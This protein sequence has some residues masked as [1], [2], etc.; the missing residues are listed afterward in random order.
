MSAIKQILNGRNSGFREVSRPLTQWQEER[1]LLGETYTS[2]VEVK[3]P[4][5]FYIR[6]MRFYNANTQDFWLLTEKKLR[7]KNS[8]SWPALTNSENIFLDFITIILDNLGIVTKREIMINDGNIAQEDIPYFELLYNLQTELA[9]IIQ[10]VEASYTI[11]SDGTRI[12]L[13]EDDSDK[14]WYFDY[15]P[16]L[17]LYSEI[18]R[19]V[20]AIAKQQAETKK[21]VIETKKLSDTEGWE[22]ATEPTKPKIKEWIPE[23]EA[24]ALSELQYNYSLENL[25]NYLNELKKASENLFDKTAASLVRAE[26]AVKEMQRIQERYIETEKEAKTVAMQSASEN[27]INSVYGIFNTEKSNIFN[28]L[29]YVKNKYKSMAW[30]ESFKRIAEE[31][32]ASEFIESLPPSRTIEEIREET[33]GPIYAEQKR[34]ALEKAEEAGKEFMEYDSESTLFQDLLEKRRRIN[35]E[36]EELLSLPEG[37]MAF[38]ALKKEEQR[39]DDAIRE[40]FADIE[41]QTEVKSTLFQ[42]I[43]KKREEAEIL[44][45]EEQ[46]MFDQLSPREQADLRNLLEVSRKEKPV[47][48]T[49]WIAGG[50]IALVLLSEKK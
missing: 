12:F 36:Q 5:K 42:D 24:K 21:V 35:A 43:L 33:F 19:W 23:S 27:F 49:K 32:E 14:Y 46:A 25:Q 13:F 6:Y 37:D 2:S 26:D 22:T 7:H 47:N 20:S 44:D 17:D 16:L 29:D 1:K 10:R 3:Q 34:I 8:S 45:E 28:L 38:E 11:K 50:I 30:F 48:Y 31:R 15:G 18:K 40:E 9:K 41:R 39:I 4:D